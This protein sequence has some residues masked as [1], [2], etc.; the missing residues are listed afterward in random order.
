MIQYMTREQFP[1]YLFLEYFN[2]FRYSA[3]RGLLFSHVGW[4][5]FKPS[6]ARMASIDRDDLEK[7]PGQLLYS[8]QA[9]SD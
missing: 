5:F 6:Y 8:S 1:T 7:D 9:T 3:S 4:I 2:S